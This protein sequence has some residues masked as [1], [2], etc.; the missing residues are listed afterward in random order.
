MKK[1][2]IRVHIVYFFAISNGLFPHLFFQ[3]LVYPDIF[4][5]IRIIYEVIYR[6]LKFIDGVKDLDDIKV[7]SEYVKLPLTF[8]NHKNVLY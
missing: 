2:E 1:G 8:F 7:P 6:I 5:I 3:V 4:S